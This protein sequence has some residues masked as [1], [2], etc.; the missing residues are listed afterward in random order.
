VAGGTDPT[1]GR[2]FGRRL[3]AEDHGGGPIAKEAG[4]NENAGVVIEI[5][6]GGTDFHADHEDPAS[7][8]RL[9]LGGGLVQGREG[10][11]A[12]LT[13]EIEQRGGAGKPETF[14]NI[15]GEARAEIASAGGNEKSIDLTG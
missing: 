11:P 1:D 14:G 10:S 15:T 5:T 13:H 3:R 8:A 12:A 2:A 9:D 6:G 7:A 4:A